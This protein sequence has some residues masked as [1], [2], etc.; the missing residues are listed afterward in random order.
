MFQ[1]KNRFFNFR[2]SNNKTIK[3]LYFSGIAQLLEVG[4]ILQQV[5][6]HQLGLMTK[7]VAIKTAVNSTAQSPYP[8]DE[9]IIYSTRY[10]RTFQSAMALMY[11]FIPVERW[12]HL[13]VQE[14]HSLAFCFSD[15]ACPYAEKLKEL[16][17]QEYSK[18]L[19]KHPTISAVVQWIGTNV[20]QNPNP[21]MQAE[22]VRDALMSLLCHDA[23]LPCRKATGY[24]DYRN[25]NQHDMGVGTTEESADLINI[26]QD[27]EMNGILNANSAQYSNNRV[28]ESEFNIRSN[29][30]ELEGCVETSHVTALLS[31]ADW[32]S[33]KESKNKNTRRQ[34]LLRAYG[35]MRNIVNY[36]LKI[37][38]GSV[39][40]FVLYSGHDRTM[41][42]IISA[43]G[44][45]SSQSYF[46]P[47]ASRM[48]FEVYR[49]DNDLSEYYFRVVLNGKDVTRSI[50]FCEGSK[51]L[52]ISKDSRGNKADL[53]PIENIIRFIHDDYFAS[54][55]VTNFK[56]ACTIHKKN[57]F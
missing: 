29:E 1:S 43:L 36:M 52:R 51:S 10:R 5:Y 42:F 12:L 50:Q 53:C 25:S 14:S 11:A 38:S 37:V 33:V 31:Y 49:S 34:G 19:H 3:N 24:G 4:H 20:L 2:Q 6:G 56:D 9:I 21:N 55:N 27:M 45:Q 57:D 15:C 26:D 47:Y 39:T 18:Q 35:L 16:T 41:Q 17:N 8:Q 13:T 44:L 32:Q 46:I 40:K 23:P 7:P 54:L 48:A 30:H 28:Y 22:E